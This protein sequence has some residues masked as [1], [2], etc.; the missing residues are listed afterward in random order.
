MRG[1]GL[2]G[3]APGDASR[4]TTRIPSA[5][6]VTVISMGTGGPAGTRRETEAC[7]DRSVAVRSTP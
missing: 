3:R 5:G 4:V 6:T 7:A 2:A 1:S